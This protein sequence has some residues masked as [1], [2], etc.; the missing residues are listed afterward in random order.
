VK[1]A[2]IHASTFG[3]G[4]KVAEEFRSQASA[5]GLLVSVLHVKDRKPADLP[6]AD[7]YV[8]SSPGRMGKPP[9]RVRRFLRR[10][11]LPVGTP[12]ALLT[13][14]MA[15][16]PDKKTG[17]MPTEEELANWQRIRPIMASIL[18]AKGARMVAEDVVHV[19][20]LKGPLEDGWQDIVTGFLARLPL[21]AAAA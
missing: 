11:S 7:L 19:T 3:N 6:A 4:A 20:G 15:A 8:F 16:R 9:R 12:Y 13:T 18:D 14:E 2:Y 1:I 5:L 21:P 10:I 17:R